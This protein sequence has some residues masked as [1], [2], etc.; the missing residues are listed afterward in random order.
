MR[1]KWTW[2]HTSAPPPIRSFK[3][4]PDEREE[5]NEPALIPD[6]RSNRFRVNL[7]KSED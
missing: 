5:A 4:T 2:V 3:I 7:P 1:S 6:E